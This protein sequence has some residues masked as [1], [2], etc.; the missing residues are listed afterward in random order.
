METKIQI[1]KVS[2]FLSWQR[3]GSLTLSPS[4]QRRTVWSAAAK[5]YL[6]DTIV[7]GLPVPIV[8]VRERLD[9]DLQRTVREVVDGQQRLRTLFGFIAPD[10]LTDLDPSRDVFEVLSKHNTDIAGRPFAR[11]PPDVKKALLSYEFGTYVLPPETED[12][13]VLKIFARI[14]STGVRLN[15]QELRNAEFF[16]DF[17][18]LMYELALEQLDRWRQWGIFNEEAIAR[19]LEVEFVSDVTV[20]MVRGEITGKTQNRLDEAYRQYDSNF[21]WSAKV[22]GRFRRVMDMIDDSVGPVLKST[23][24]TSEV[25]FFSLWALVYDL[26]YDLDTPLGRRAKP[27]AIR[28]TRLRAAV[29]KASEKIR[30]ED[31]NDEVLDA[32]RRAS[33]DTGRRRTR[34]TFLLECYG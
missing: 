2:D 32:I 19:M 25:N 17:K 23:V 24:F 18:Q 1:F 10:V 8:F 13:D 5:S 21:P 11:L 34:H 29:V 12:R 14:N 27:A 3:E 15:G 20:T 26:M 4:F 16:G 7:R 22:A 33:S 9:L 31:V 6:I 28:P 30:S